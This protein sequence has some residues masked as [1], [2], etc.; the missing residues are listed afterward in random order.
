MLDLNAG[1][2][3]R[4]S[5]EKLE[6]FLEN[7]PELFVGLKVRRYALLL[8]ASGEWSSEIQFYI[9]G[10]SWPQLERNRHP[11]ERTLREWLG[12]PANFHISYALD[13]SGYA[14]QGLM[15]MN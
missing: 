7:H 12:H 13:S 2:W 9:S 6:R 8:E 4:I 11:L 15:E 14:S 10:D 3:T 1:W 5:P